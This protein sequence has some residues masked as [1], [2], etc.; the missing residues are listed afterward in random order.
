[1]DFGNFLL[2]RHEILLLIIALVLVIVEIF[3]PQNKK[4][5]VV[6]LAI[7]LFGI[8]TIIGFFSLTYGSLF[9][10]MFQTN[11]MIQFF[12]NVLN[13]GVLI[14]ILQSADWI[15]EK[16][17]QGN[18]GTEFFILMFSTTT[19]NYHYMFFFHNLPV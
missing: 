8:H 16:I 19:A 17:V 14:L 5:N 15:Q 18:K 9:G 10:G 6:H 7:F 3:I 2:M 4:T 12:K 1:M 13:V 11:A